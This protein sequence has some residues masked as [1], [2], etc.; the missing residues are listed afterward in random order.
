MPLPPIKRP[1]LAGRRSKRIAAMMAGL[2]VLL[3]AAGVAIWSLKTGR[4]KR[5]PQPASATPAHA[6]PASALAV[7]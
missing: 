3:L 2:V 7:K 4:L 6:A 1:A 5:A